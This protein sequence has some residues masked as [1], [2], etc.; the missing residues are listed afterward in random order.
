MA[1]GDSGRIVIEIAPE[2]KRELYAA[3]AL[4]GSTLKDWFIRNAEAYCTHLN[5]GEL[6][7]AGEMLKTKSFDSVEVRENHDLKEH[8]GQRE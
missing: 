7:D 1:K 3:L 2:L 8:E 5:Q 4:S 6:F